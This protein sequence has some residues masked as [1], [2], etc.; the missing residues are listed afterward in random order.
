MHRL[1]PILLV[2]ACTSSGGDPS[3]APD[4]SP[5]SD[6]GSDD[7][8]PSIGTPQ[9]PPQG[10]AALKA[11]LAEGHYLAWSCESAAHAARPPGAHGENRICSNTALSTSTSGSYPVGAASVKELYGNGQIAGFAVG[12]KVASGAGA[13]T[14]YWYE[15]V[16][17]TT[18]YADG[19]NVP[20]CV[21]CHQSAARDHVFTQVP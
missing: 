2:A 12:R 6:A 1:A 14:W 9:L 17:D 19:V 20:L 4:A 3:T 5:S 10:Q 21:S 11:W 15:G 16:G 13:S 7:G 8:D 18:I